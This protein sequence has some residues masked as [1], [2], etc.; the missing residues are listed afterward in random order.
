MRNTRIDS[1]V[2]TARST[3]AFRSVVD[4]KRMDGTI[5]AVNPLRPGDMKENQR[6]EKEKQ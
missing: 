5:N 3:K 2:C 6:E 1:A 4:V